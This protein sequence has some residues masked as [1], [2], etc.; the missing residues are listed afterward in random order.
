MDLSDLS[1]ALMDRHIGAGTLFQLGVVPM[2]YFENTD[3]GSVGAK[4]NRIILAAGELYA[5][6]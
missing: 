3:Q 1:C 5:D 4:E 2:F 6:R